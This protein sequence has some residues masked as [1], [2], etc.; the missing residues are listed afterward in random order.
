MP[1]PN[2]SISQHYHQQTK[3]SPETIK[4][5]AGAIDWDS[6]PVPFKD[7]KI[8]T[9]YPLKPYL[10]ED[11]SDSNVQNL[12]ANVKQ[13]RKRLSRLLLCSYGLTVKVITQGG[14]PIYLRSSPSAGALYPAELYLVSRGTDV[15]ASGLYHYQ[16][17]GHSLVQF[18]DSDVWQTLQESCFWHPSL[19]HTQFALIT[20]AVYSRSIWRYRA[21]AYRRILL[22]TG[23]L[24]GNVELACA[25]NQYRPHLIGGFADD[26][27]NQMLYLNAEQE[28]GLTIMA[29]AD[30]LNV[31]QNLPPYP[32]VLPSSTHPSDSAIASDELLPR[33]HEAASI[34][35][36]QNVNWKTSASADGLSSNLPPEKRSQQSPVLSM[37]ESSE[38]PLSKSLD[39]YNFPFCL[40]IEMGI[41]PPIDWEAELLR[42]EAT[43]LKRRS[44]R[45]YNGLNLRLDDLKQIFDFTYQPHHYPNQGLDRSPD[46]FDLSL[47]ETFIV[48]SG[49]DDLDEGCYY[50]APHAQ[51]LR[52]IRFRNFRREL[53]FLCL[54]QDLGRDAAVVVFHTADLQKAIDCYGD[55]AYRYLH[56][57]AGHLGQRLNLAAIRLGLGVS[58]IAGFFDDSVND[59]LGIPPDEA[60]LYITTLGQVA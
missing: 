48:V 7:Y 41:E 28:S 14:E 49:V 45:N 47:I 9:E 21:R 55:R 58:G 40:K 34:P 6:Q 10:E 13:Q 4:Q 39:K 33:L 36:T 44:T 53:H 8:G 29:L 32:T 11:T 60:V 17:K 25:I 57:D 52:Q 46:Y 30:L 59:V 31:N 38:T 16:P 1:N 35:P 5:Q 18:W 20:T 51:E 37:A 22:D 15:L 50:Y 24:L 26:A 54:K 12:S 2:L 19:E 42:L 27:L 23:H 56:M 3:Y 43:I